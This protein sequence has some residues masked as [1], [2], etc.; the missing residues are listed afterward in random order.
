VRVADG[1]EYESRSLSPEA[2]E[3]FARAQLREAAHDDAGALVEYER[4]LAEDSGAPEL[5]ARRGAVRCRLARRVDDAWAQRA[6]EDFARAVHSD[7]HSASAWLEIAHC[8]AR[9]QRQAEAFSAIRRAAAAD[10]ESAAIAR[11]F[12]SYAERVGELALAR[13]FSDA[14]VVRRPSERAA[15]LSL[16][17][18]AQRTHDLAR[19]R[20]ARSALAELGESAESNER[21]LT[22]ALARDDAPEAGRVALALNLRSGELAARALRAGAYRT[23]KTVAERVHAADPSDADAWVSVLTLADLERQPERLATLLHEAPPEVDS[24]SAAG[25][26]L[27]GELLAR[28]VGDDAERAWLASPRDER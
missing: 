21:A 12:V 27:F 25:R 28:L 8:A 4:A 20:A 5:L 11:A 15:W 3:H 9:F 7:A 24:L 6:K 22:R 23:A 14:W 13:R 18:F 16:A 2:Y 1:I 17:E 10:P 26:A 19:A